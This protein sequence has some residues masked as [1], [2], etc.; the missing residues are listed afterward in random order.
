MLDEATFHWEKL[1]PE[2]FEQ[3][4]FFALD[5][6]GFKNIEWRKGGEGITATD[7]GRDLEAIYSKLEPD[8]SLTLEKWWVEVKYR[9]HTLSP[10]VVQRTVINALG[11]QSVDVIAIATNQVITNKTLDWIKEFQTSQR[12]PRVV[13]WQRHDL[14]R[15]LRKY[16]RTIA[17]FFPES[18]TLA[19][20]LKA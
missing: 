13:I 4:V 3:L 12:R 1:T 6:M 15:L 14:D 16:P 20:R 2:E 11:R 10:D 9:T 8:D 7:G 18:L 19:E 5:D 17:R